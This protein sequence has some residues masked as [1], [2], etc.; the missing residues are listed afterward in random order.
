[1]RFLFLVASLLWAEAS[2]AQADLAI[3]L[4]GPTNVQHD[5]L[6]GYQIHV[7]NLG[8]TMVRNGI[9]ALPIPQGAQVMSLTTSGNI[10]SCAYRGK[11]S[12]A[13]YLEFMLEQRMLSL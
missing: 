1:M 4:S 3:Q 9:L 6:A 12:L 13:A 2:F 11:I 8:R 5:S 7:S 10:V